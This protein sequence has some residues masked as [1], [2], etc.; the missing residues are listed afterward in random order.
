MNSEEKQPSEEGTIKEKTT[1]KL[2]DRRDFSDR[3]KVNTDAFV[4]SDTEGNYYVV[5]REILALSKVSPAAKAEVEKQLNVQQNNERINMGAG[6]T[7]VGV[8]SLQE[9]ANW[10]HYSPEISWPNGAGVGNL[11]NIGHGK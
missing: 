11:V 1:D 3:N 6:L 9:G 5:P 7:F 4:I 8:M 10:T 2:V